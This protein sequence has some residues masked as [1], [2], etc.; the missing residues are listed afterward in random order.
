MSK[1]GVCSE[2]STEKLEHTF[3][4]LLRLYA[5]RHYSRLLSFD[6][7]SI[8]LGRCLRLMDGMRILDAEHA[9][10]PNICENR[11]DHGYKA[12]ANS[13]SPPLCFLRAHPRS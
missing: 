10:S 1:M 5:Y 13:A 9:L 2:L 3:T 7:L 6:A 4:F 8:P 12:F 11:Q